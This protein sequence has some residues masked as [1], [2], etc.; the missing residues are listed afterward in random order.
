M[1]A[2]TFQII[3]LI[4]GIALLVG[5]VMLGVFMIKYHNEMLSDPCKLCLDRGF[6]CYKVS[7]FLPQSNLMPKLNLTVP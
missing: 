3:T 4:L 2:L 1:K 6:S 7:D 5:I